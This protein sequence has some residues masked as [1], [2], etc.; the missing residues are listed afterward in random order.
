V[1]VGVGHLLDPDAEGLPG[2]P[3]LAVT[4]L[5]CPGCGITRAG[6]RLVRGDVL[7]AVALNPLAVAVVV[8]GLAWLLSAYAA[9]AGLRDRPLQAPAWL[10][11]ATPALVIG[12]WVL[13]N[14]PAAPFSA[15]AP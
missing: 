15:L 9:A 2:C 4:G 5:F 13:R 14:V 3:F 8:A 12:F 11:R 7:A 6:L 1:A 10:V